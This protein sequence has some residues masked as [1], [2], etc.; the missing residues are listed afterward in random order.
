MKTR[1]DFAFYGINVGEVEGI[2]KRRMSEEGWTFP[3]L[4]DT[5]SSVSS[6]YGIT[7]HPETFLIDRKGRIAAVTLGARNWQGEYAKSLIEQLLAENVE[8]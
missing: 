3:A 7:G 8:G 1:D 4:L 2:V 5:R 6:K